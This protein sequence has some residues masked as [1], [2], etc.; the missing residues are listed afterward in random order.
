M[1]RSPRAEAGGPFPRSPRGSPAVRGQNQCQTPRRGTVSH[2]PKLEDVPEPNPQLPEELRRRIRLAWEAQCVPGFDWGR[3]SHLRYVDVAGLRFRPTLTDLPVNAYSSAWRV[4]AL[5]PLGLAIVL[6]VNVWTRAAYH[7]LGEVLLCNLPILLL[8]GVSAFL[9][10]LLGRKRAIHVGVARDAPLSD[11]ES[12][13]AL[14]HPTGKARSSPRGTARAGLALLHVGHPPSFE[15]LG[16]VQDGGRGASAP[17]GA[18]CS[19][20]GGPRLA[21]AL[22]RDRRAPDPRQAVTITPR[23]GKVP[24]WAAPRSGQEWWHVAPCARVGATRG[25][26]LRDGGQRRPGRDRTGEGA[27][28]AHAGAGRPVVPGPDA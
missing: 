3:L 24:R 22:A 10:R 11:T 23:P 18:P 25:A 17:D 12:A 1:G 28:E 19:R 8:L 21:G 6:A 9:F 16:G 4:L 5:G 14:G 13:H 2:M 15:R 7:P 27:A 26:E 20:L